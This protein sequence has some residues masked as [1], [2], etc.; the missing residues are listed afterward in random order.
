MQEIASLALEDKEKKRRLNIAFSVSTLPD[1]Y[2]D[3]KGGLYQ[4]I[5][6]GELKSQSDLDRLT[7]WL[8]VELRHNGNV[9][10][11]EVRRRLGSRNSLT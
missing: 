11:E 2:D 5:K 4:L 3:L 8:S 10:Q 9:S 6:S 1:V 7:K